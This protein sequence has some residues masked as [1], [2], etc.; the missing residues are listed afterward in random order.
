MT[1]YHKLKLIILAQHLVAIA[2]LIW[3]F[4]WSGLVVAFL[5]FL[6]YYA[7]GMILGFHRSFA[8]KSYEISNTSKRLMLVAGSLSGMGSSIGWVGQHRW[9]HAYADQSDKDP[10]YS[11]KGFW[12]KTVA[13]ALYPAI[14]EFKVTVIKDLIR[15]KDHMFMHQHYYKILFVWVTILALISPW[16]VVYMW[17]LPAVLCYTDLTLVGVFG[18]VVGKQPYHNDDESRDS[19]ILSIFTLGESYQNLHHLHAS[20]LIQGKFDLIGIVASKFLKE[21]INES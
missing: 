14:K 2:G 8:H 20:K 6:V 19:H 12:S 16:A 17:A 21:T 10:Y 11:V 4:S 7:Y 5:M 13:W 18:H 1:D 15:D 3:L 9:H